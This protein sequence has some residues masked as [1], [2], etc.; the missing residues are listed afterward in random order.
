MAKDKPELITACKSC[1]G[2][3]HHCEEPDCECP[4][5]LCKLAR[6][7]AAKEKK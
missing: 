5:Y 2:G 6:E 3:L 4:L 7:T 1:F